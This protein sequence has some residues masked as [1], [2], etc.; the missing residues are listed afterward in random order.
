MTQ[1]TV[2]KRLRVL[3]PWMLNDVCIG[4]RH[5]FFEEKANN[6]YEIEIYY[7]ILLEGSRSKIGVSAA[8]AQLFHDPAGA[9]SELKA[10]FTNNRMKTLL[11]S[12]SERDLARLELR[13]NQPQCPGSDRR[14]A[15]WR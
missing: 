14:F 4:Y 5:Q 6:L 12:Q 9:V 13:V 10:Q 15:T 1:P 11:R 7:C 3:L 2:S 8:L